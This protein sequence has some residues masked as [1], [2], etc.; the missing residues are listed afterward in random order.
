MKS[1]NAKNLIIAILFL[2]LIA[3]MGARTL[4]DNTADIRKTI[5]ENLGFEMVSKLDLVFSENPAYKNKW[6][7]VNGA[8][9]KTV[10]QTADLQKDWFVLNDDSMMYSLDKQSTEQIQ[11]YADSVSE[12]KECLSEDQQLFYIQLPFKIDSN[13]SMPVGCKEY[14]NSNADELTSALVS[15]GVTVLMCARRRTMA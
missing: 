2:L 12:L 13:K 11:E 7:N 6:I 14:G 3:I 10:G 8:F 15:K 4:L 5:G 1:L 9:L